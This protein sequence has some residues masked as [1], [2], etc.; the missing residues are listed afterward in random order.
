MKRWIHIGWAKD[1][2]A[3]YDVKP[4][5]HNSKSHW[6]YDLPEQVWVEFLSLY[7][8]NRDKPVLYENDPGW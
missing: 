5:Q 6:L 1:L 8:R 7:E 4:I 3:Y 2:T